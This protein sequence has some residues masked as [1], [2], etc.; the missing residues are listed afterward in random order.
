[1]GS[2]AK[3]IAIV[4]AG[5]RGIGLLER[6]AANVPELYGGRLVVHLIDPFP[7]GPGR[8]WRFKQSPLLRM[9]SMPADVTMFTDDTV[10]C[11]GP[12][13]PGPTLAE[14]VVGVR[15]G[16]LAADVNPELL[17]ELRSVTATTFPTRRLQSAYLD[18]FY[19]W[20]LDSLPDSVDVRVHE[21]TVVD[22]TGPADD[23]QSVWLSGRSEPVLADVVVMTVGHL[24]ADPSPEEAELADH[25]ARHGLRY[26][27]PAYTADLDLSGVAA[28]ESVLLRGFGLAFVDLQVLLTEGRGG[29]FTPGPGDSLVYHPSGAEPLLY[30]GSRRGVPYHA[31]PAYPLQGNPAP[32]PK[33]FGP[34][35]VADLL[36]RPERL[37]L[38]RDLWPLMAKEIGWGYYHELF[39]AHPDRV[40]LELAEFADRYAEL[41]W[42][43]EE[44][45]SLIE[46]A[47]PGAEDRL[48]FA[49][50]DRPLNGLRFIDR[51]ALT[52]H[53]SRYIEADLARREDSEFSADLGAFLALLSVFGQI[54]HLVTAAKLTPESQVGAVDGW[55]FGFF[56][57][58][59]SGPP[60]HRLRELLALIEAGVVRLVGP[61]MWV[62]ADDGKFVA[63]SPSVPGEIVATTLVEARLPKPSVRR[64]TDP[65]IRTLYER[66]ELVEEIL[67]EGVQEHTTGRITTTVL[68]GLVD[69]D[70]RS[71]ARR[72]AFGPHTSIRSPGAFTR[73]QTNAV[74]FRQ[75]DAVAR[76]ILSD[77]K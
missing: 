66:G 54:A 40:R 33:F 9:N 28:G 50:L 60:G 77:F 10:Q 72:Y 15:A 58:F 75:N 59:A 16:E 73:P 49:A 76:A 43:S 55:W 38:R 41:D 37:G 23:I 53:V 14:W 20:V 8:V 3:A 67:R 21:A 4:G 69:A 2:T 34:P 26:V 11:A 5:P 64:A 52:H 36:A 62:R 61:D 65:L 48:D 56:S 74:G 45:A 24:D 57:Y 13:R 68:G 31:K 39:A 25:A 18:W 6:I 17:E 44:M 70:G 71:H 46:K 29:R 63:G 35:E 12:I 47:V 22:I 1:M 51:T 19:A 32:L 7:P 42:D 27:P 30:V